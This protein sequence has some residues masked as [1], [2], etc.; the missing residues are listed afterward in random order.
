MLQRNSISP[1]DKDKY[2][3]RTPDQNEAKKRKTDSSHITDSE[4]EKSDQDLVVDV[5][6]ED[7]L[8]RF[9]PNGEHSREKMNGDG[10]DIKKDRPMSPRSNASS[11]SSTPSSKPIKENDKPPTPVSK[12]ATPTSSGG[13][14]AGTSS[15][16]KPVGK[17]PPL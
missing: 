10:S 2:R 16:L 17:A 6:N 5:A 9:L 8:P 4:D 1:N 12:S 3:S 14:T 13:A 7:P 15:G 11:N